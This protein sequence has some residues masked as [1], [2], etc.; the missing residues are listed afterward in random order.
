MLTPD[1]DPFPIIETERL[2]LRKIVMED[3]VELFKLR[4]SE[5]VMQYIDR[6]IHKTIEDT[7]KLIA[8]ITDLLEKNDG[9]NW[10]IT[11]KNHPTL[12]GNICLFNLQKEHYRGE[13]G[14]ILSPEFY[15]K[16]I[17][18]ESIEAV[19]KYGFETMKLHSI[20]AHVNPD[21]LPSIK[22]LEKNKFIREA[23]FKE[24]HYHNGKFVDFAIYS[25]LNNK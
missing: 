17:M 4:S 24:S 16:G 20:E 5:L 3:A 15:R 9:I 19:I 25:R 10:G 7:E 13:L 21:N 2:I 6:P 11:L 1:F 23:Y 22:I 18:H 12:I 8:I 14:Y